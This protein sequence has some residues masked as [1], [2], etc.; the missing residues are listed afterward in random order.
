MLNVFEKLLI[1][2]LLTVI[3]CATDY[4]E[5]EARTYLNFA[6]AAYAD[7]PTPC[8]QRV[9][10]PSSAY[11]LISTKT[12]SCDALS[13]LCSGYIV[14]SDV[15]RQ[16]VVVF[17]G[18]KTDVQLLLEGWSTLQPQQDF[19]GMGKV[20]Q[21]F[22]NAV[23]LLFDPVGTTLSNP[24]WRDYKVVFTGHSLGAAL[25]ALAAARTAAQ[26]LR[27]SNQIKLYT[28]GEPRVGN[29]QFAASF[30]NLVPEAFRVVFRSDI[31][32]HL[33]GCNK[34]YINGTDTDD[35]QP[36]DPGNLVRGYHHQMEIWY[37]TCMTPGCQY[38]ICTG[39]PTG[40]DF[41]CSDLIKFDM[42]N[43]SMYIWDHRHYFDL[44]VTQYGEIGCDANDPSVH[45]PPPQSSNF[46]EKLL[47]TAGSFASKLGIGTKK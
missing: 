36:C 28:F 20:N 37:P 34:D 8:L 3:Q 6:A 32:P 9:F 2:V 27:N 42:N 43:V 1:F 14:K 13:Q 11:Q 25:A 16:I 30:N 41:S 22:G 15:L 23:D 19:Y 10:P 12:E 18:T 47:F 39:T 44:K 29:V 40:E 45:D 7:S 17:R 38:K 26:G 31:V 33:P 46:V 5:Q 21:Y 4:N 35:S 24:Q